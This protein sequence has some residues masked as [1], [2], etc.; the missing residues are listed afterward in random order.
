MVMRLA[1]YLEVRPKTTRM[2]NLKVPLNGYI[3]VLD[4]PKNLLRRNTLAYLS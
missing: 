3:P 2:D 4:W 1:Y